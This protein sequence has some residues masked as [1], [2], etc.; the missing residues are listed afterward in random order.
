MDGYAYS[1]MPVMQFLDDGGRPMVGGLLCTFAAGTD[2][3]L[4]T[5]DYDGKENPT[6]IVLDSRGETPVSV[7]LDVTKN[8]KFR[9]LRPDRSMVWE[10]DGIRSSGIEFGDSS[11]TGISAEKPITMKVSG[12]KLVIGFDGSEI[13][14]KLEAL[15]TADKAE[16]EAREKADR[17]ENEARTAADE[18]L[19]QSIAESVAAE[20]SE[21]KSADE[22]LSESIAAKQN[23]LKA[24]DNIKIESDTV[25]VTGRRQLKVKSPLYVYSKTNSAITLSCNTSD[26]SEAVEAEAAARKSADEGLTA[27]INAEETLRKEADGE[28]KES[29]NSNFQILQKEFESETKS[30]GQ[31]DAALQTQINNLKPKTATGRLS[32]STTAESATEITFGDWTFAFKINSAQAGTITLT[33]PG[34]TSAD[35]FS[36]SRTYGN[37]VRVVGA[38]CSGGYT[39]TFFGNG[40]FSLYT[41]R[42]VIDVYW[43]GGWL[44]MTLLL[45]TESSSGIFDYIIEEF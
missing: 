29:L 6:E 33:N 42:I 34:V 31:A 11:V 8:Y 44:R 43:A 1:P 16:S 18:K 21:R 7:L 32:V 9:L 14:A 15:E 20:A 22:A 10:R 41:S 4:P 23:K 36:E 30:R 26:V 37:T 19:S 3:P 45:H 38:D 24:G 25:S 17:A 2:T 5:T 12:T 28:L 35:I 40:D 13:T 27:S 39:G